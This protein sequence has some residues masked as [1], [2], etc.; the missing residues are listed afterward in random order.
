MSHSSEMRWEEAAAIISNAAGGT[1]TALNNAEENY[2]ELT[3]VYT[4]AGSTDQLMADLLF[5]DDISAEA[6]NPAVATAAE[7]AKVADLKAAIQALHQL[8]QGL[9]DVSITQVDRAII[10][11]RMS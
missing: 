11:R 5:A 4:F 6:R 10:L 2:L 3:E 1:L 9:N 7:V 8:W